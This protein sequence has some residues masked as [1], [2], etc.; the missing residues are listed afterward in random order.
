MILIILILLWAV[1]FL[2][3]PFD[4]T[5]TVFG[6][7]EISMVVIA[8]NIYYKLCYL[9]AINI[10]NSSKLMLLVILLILCIFIYNPYFNLYFNVICCLKYFLYYFVVLITWYLLALLKIIKKDKK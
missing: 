5:H 1:G 9:S 4:L 7:L 3:S 8:Y 6:L 2:I 10:K